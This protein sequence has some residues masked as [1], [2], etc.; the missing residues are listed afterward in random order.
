MKIIQVLIIQLIQII[1]TNK[2]NN[3]ILVTLY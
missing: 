1:K 2:H 3:K